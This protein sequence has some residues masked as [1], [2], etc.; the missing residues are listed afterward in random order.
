MSNSQGGS[1]PRLLSREELSD[2]LRISI[3]HISRFVSEGK[4]KPIRLGRRVLFSDSEV[5]RFLESQ[6]NERIDEV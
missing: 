5:T 4:L 1:M 6:Q 2:V 3:R